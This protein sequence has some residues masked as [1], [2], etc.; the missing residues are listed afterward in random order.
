[1]NRWESDLHPNQKYI[2]KH[3]S[4]SSQF[5]QINSRQQHR[6]FAWAKITGATAGNIKPNGP[7]LRSPL[8]AGGR[9][10]QKTMEGALWFQRPSVKA[11]MFGTAAHRCFGTSQR[12]DNDLG[13]V[14]AGHK[15]CLQFIS[16]FLLTVCGVTQSHCSHL[17]VS[18]YAFC[19]KEV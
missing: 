1:M 7:C 4:R 5:E 12:R 16:L 11:E 6:Y 18:C 10:Q 19:W 14:T 17:R 2:L 3:I 15:R 9:A 13:E 8:C